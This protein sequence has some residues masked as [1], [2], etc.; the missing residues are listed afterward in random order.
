MDEERIINPLGL[1][2]QILS[3]KLQINFKFQGNSKPQAPNL[4]EI[5]KFVILNFGHCD[6]FVFC[7]L[8]FVISPFRFRLRRIV[9]LIFDIWKLI[10]LGLVKVG[11]DGT[12]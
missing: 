2:S 12:D 10:Y 3:T 5:P 6:L 11:N 9:C 7:N 8:I 4:K 1:K